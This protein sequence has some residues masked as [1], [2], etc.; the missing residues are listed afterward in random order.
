MSTTA[1][2]DCEMTA[3]GSQVKTEVQGVARAVQDAAGQMARAARENW[4]AVVPVPCES[5]WDAPIPHLMLALV[6]FSENDGTEFEAPGEADLVVAGDV[7]D[8]IG[9]GVVDAAVKPDDQAAKAA[10]QQKRR[11]DGE[12]QGVL[13]DPL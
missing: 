13:V 11:N 9:H 5:V 10:D 1:K 4:L 12:Q 3:D 8:G 7:G 2:L 6:A